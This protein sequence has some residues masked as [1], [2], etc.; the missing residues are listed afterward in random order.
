MTQV[1]AAAR[2]KNRVFF[3]NR[4]YRPDEPATAQLLTDLAETLAA[5][6]HVVTV[7]AS[8]PGG[9]VPREETIAGVH[10]LRVGGKRR[11]KAG[12]T[13]KALDFAS[14]YFGA[15]GRLLGIAR[16][17]DALVALTDPPLIG[18][19]VGLVARLRRA[20][21]FHW[22]QDIYPELAIELAGQGWLRLTRPWRNAAWRDAERCVTLGRDMVSLLAEVGVAKEKIT[23]VPNW[24]PAGL[25]PHPAPGE[26]PLRRA[27][28]LERKFVVL[29]SGNFGR[30]HDLLSVLAVAEA[31]RDND[32]IV[33][34]FIGDGA[35]RPI[36]EQHV[37]E[38][39][40]TNVHFRPAQARTELNHSLALGDVHLVTLRAGCER[41]VFPSKIAGIAAI[42][43]P[44]VFLGPP[45]CEV[46]RTL[47]DGGFGQA[48]AATDIDGASAA[49]VALKNDAATRARRGQVAAEFA[50]RAGGVAAAADRWDEI[51]SP[52]GELAASNRQR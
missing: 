21:L 9:T 18:I 20:R 19:G 5:R 11:S 14:F 10:V 48:F 15:I 22:V 6:G 47:E 33:F 2:A 27:W 24:A 16:R 29:Y 23:I 42:G 44:I 13:G 50:R 51:L 7:I 40:L 3:I 12:L 30:V 28:N 34:L 1:S 17:G 46:A 26:N 49:I 35:Q 25:S 38:H 4:F 41:L 52:A 32:E 43:R 45:R 31:L 37:A 39:R 8:H 36:L